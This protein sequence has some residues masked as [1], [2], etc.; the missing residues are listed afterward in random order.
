[1]FAMGPSVAEAGVVATW[2]FCSYTALMT[3]FFIVASVLFGLG[4]TAWAFVDWRHA[5]GSLA[6]PSVQGEIVKSSV[7]R[8]TSRRFRWNWQVEYRYDV[9]GHAYTGWR[10]YFGSSVPIAIARNIVRKFPAQ[11]T[12]TV[13]YHPS[14]HTKSV[15]IPGVNKYTR[16]SFLVGPISWAF[17]LALSTLA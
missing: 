16:L 1:M 6:W 9:D 15:L 8:Y 7:T 17:A 11:S 10:T 3:Q 13:Y 14:V 2:I 5:R 4:M 12:V